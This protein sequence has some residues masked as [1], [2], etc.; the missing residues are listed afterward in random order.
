MAWSVR[1]KACGGVFFEKGEKRQT[2]KEERTH[3]WVWVYVPTIHPSTTQQ[4]AF[5]PHHL[6]L[7]AVRQHQHAVR[8]VRLSDLFRKCGAESCVSEECQEQVCEEKRKGA[9]FHTKPPKSRAW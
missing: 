1:M 9:P 3:L 6:V 7:G 4:H 8:I 2:V 5:T